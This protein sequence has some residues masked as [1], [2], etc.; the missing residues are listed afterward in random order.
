MNCIRGFTDLKKQRQLHYESACQKDTKTGRYKCR[1]IPELKVNLGQRE[2]RF[3]CG[4]NGNFRTRF[5]LA[6]L[7]CLTEA[8][9][10]LNSSAMLKRKCV[11]AVS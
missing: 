4:R 5:H 11:L 10:S 8:G 9:R 3:Q 2:Y 7:H 1:Q 6:S